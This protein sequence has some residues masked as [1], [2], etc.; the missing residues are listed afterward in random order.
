M[1]NAPRPFDQAREAFV[2]AHK[3]LNKAR[4]DEANATSRLRIAS[5]NFSIAEA[6]FEVYL[7]D[8]EMA[9]DFLPEED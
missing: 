1:T 2:A 6:A 7:R 8:G 4:E 5:V 9:Y 3:R